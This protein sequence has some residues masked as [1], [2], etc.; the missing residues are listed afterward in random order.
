MFLLAGL[1]GLTSP[2]TPLRTENSNGCR[3]VGGLE[4]VEVEDIF[5]L[6]IFEVAWP[7]CDPVCGVMCVQI[8][9]CTKTWSSLMELSSFDSRLGKL[10]L[11]LEVKIYVEGEN[12]YLHV[13]AEPQLPDRLCTTSLCR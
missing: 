2:H 5:A 10:H 6:A 8:S 1:P 7:L 11:A 4:Y 3:S 12:L 13:K 9:S